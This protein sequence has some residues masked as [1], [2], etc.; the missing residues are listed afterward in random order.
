MAKD[1]W[2]QELTG[3]APEA[4]ESEIDVFE[5]QIELKKRGKVDDKL[6]AETR[7]RRGAYGQRYDNGRRHDGVETQLLEYPAGKLQKGPETMWD[8]PGMQRIKIPFGKLEAKQLEVLADLAEEYSDQILHV[9]TR[10]DIQLHFVHIEDTPDLMRRLAAVGITTREAC[11]N[12]VRNVTACP[13]AGVCRDESFDVSPYARALTFFLLGHEAGQ[14]M[15][16]KFKVAFSGCA[17]HACGLTGFHDIGCI[18]RT[19]PGPNGAE[20][21]F[22][23]YVGGGLGPVPQ[24]AELLNEFVPEAELLPL[25]EAVCRVFARLGERANR[26]RARMKFLVKKLGIEA[27]RQLVLAERSKLTPDP[28][29]T[30]FLQRLNEPLERPLHAAASAE[31]SDDAALDRSYRR[32]R[33]TNVYAQRQPGFSAL[34]IKLPLGDFTPRQARAIVD[35]MRAYTGDTLRTTVEQNLLLR[36]VRNEDLPALY[37]ALVDIGLAEA[38]AGQLTDVTSCPGTDTCKLGISASRGLAK[39]LRR[40][41]SLVEHELEPEAQRLHVKCSGCFNSCGQHHVA[42]IGFL[43]VSRNVNGRRVPHFQLVVGGQWEA[44]GTTFGLAIGAIPSKR[45]PEAVDRLTAAYSKG[46]APDE[47]F[48]NWIFRIGRKEVK[49]LVADLTHVP[50]FEDDPELYRDWGDP[51]IYT[52]GDQGV[53]ECAGEVVSPTQFAL[54]ASERQI[55]EAQLLLDDGKLVDAARRARAAMTEAALALTRELAPALRSDSADILREF[56]RHLLDTGAFDA[57]SVG[58]KFAH[59]FVRAHEIDLDLATPRSA[60]ELIEEAQLFVD[61]A[62]Q[63]HV[64]RLQ[65]QIPI[66]PEVPA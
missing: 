61:A 63:Y 20:R 25:A 38:G 46:R 27:F 31:A 43:G 16:R 59:Y 13:I 52:T 58:G 50:P 37:R 17:Q 47:S 24:A 29:W 21:G 1:S 10:Q 45:V 19:R 44:N 11:G 28:R 57:A 56:R 12:S 62:H 30:E 33:A 60:H 18:A 40:H 42:D 26:S 48:Q 49:A 35:L 6:F 9:T 15:G 36:W 64:R 41:L 39:E 8:A 54:A 22:G 51:R 65:P 66:A 7:L 32:W 4:W 2:K 3:L 53:G 34:T 55:F 14:D 5:T 23:F